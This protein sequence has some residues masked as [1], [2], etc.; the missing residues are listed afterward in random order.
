MVGHLP[1]DAEVQ[2]LHN[3]VT[4]ASQPGT[5]AGL[6]QKGITVLHRQATG[7]EKLHRH[8]LPEQL[9]PGPVD[10]S[11]STLAQQ[12][13]QAIALVQKFSHPG[14]DSSIHALTWADVSSACPLRPDL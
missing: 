2:Q 11:H 3:L 14:G 6:L 7:A 8:R 12:C 13:L 10:R 5:E 4:A 1:L 9:M